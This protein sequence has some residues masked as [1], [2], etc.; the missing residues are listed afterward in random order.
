MTKTLD[1][2]KYTI[3]SL[4]GRYERRRVILP[5]F[6]RSYSWEKSQLNQFWDDLVL[7]EKEFAKAPQTASYF[8]GPIVVM[9]Q[10]DHIEL[11]DGQQRLATAT[12]SL[13]AMR[14]AARALDKTGSTKGA[15]LARDIQREL[16][17]KDTDPVS[18]SLTL[19]QLD[20]P[21]FVKAIKTDPPAVV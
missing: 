20:E 7:F 4:L 11:L 16:L 14:D 1:T 17:E 21:F 6:Q 15:D 10:E 8:L 5:P 12:I 2:D 19:G 3:G 18:Y 9:Q 13:G